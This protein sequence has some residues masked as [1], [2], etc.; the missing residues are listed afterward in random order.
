[1]G[2]N[3]Q[4]QHAGWFSAQAASEAALQTVQRQ[5]Q[6]RPCRVVRSN[7]NRRKRGLRLRQ[8]QH[9]CTLKQAPQRAAKH[10]SNLTGPHNCC[11]SA[12]IRCGPCNRAAQKQRTGRRHG[13]HGMHAA[14]VSLLGSRGGKKACEGCCKSCTRSPLEVINSNPGWQSTSRHRLIQYTL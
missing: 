11:G 1:M 2:R 4:Q 6:R 7:T 5:G 3:A 10:A 8:Q 13:R 9:T 14:T 12:G